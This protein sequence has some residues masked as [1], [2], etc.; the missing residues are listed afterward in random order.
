MKYSTNSSNNIFLAPGCGTTINLSSGPQLLESAA[1]FG[2]SFA[3]NY[4][5]NAICEYN[6]VATPG[7]VPV[8]E[9]IEFA[10]HQAGNNDKFKVSA[11]A[12][13]LL[14]ALEK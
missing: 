1:T 2:A 7:W 5:N 3:P 12:L 11:Y 6:I 14:L 9:V 4:P 8:F 13:F 10:V